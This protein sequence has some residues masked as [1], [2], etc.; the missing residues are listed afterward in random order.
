MQNW[1][2]NYFTEMHFLSS[3]NISMLLWLSVSVSVTSL[4]LWALCH[5]DEANQD[6]LYEIWFFACMGHFWKIP[7]PSKMFL[8]PICLLCACKGRER[9]FPFFLRLAALC[10]V[11]LRRFKIL[12][13]RW[14]GGSRKFWK[15]EKNGKIGKLHV[16][17]QIKAYCM[18]VHEDTLK[19]QNS[20]K[21]LGKK[22]KEL[23]IA[24]KLYCR[25]PCGR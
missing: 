5:C 1:V 10:M 22:L 2:A 16:T 11:L 7:C 12:L 17:Y 14:I 25:K 19:C 23:Y 24:S 4:L 6:S 20:S 15:M 13:G 21:N 8:L 9:V 3:H 18:L